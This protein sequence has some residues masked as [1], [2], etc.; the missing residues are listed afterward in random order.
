MCVNIYDDVASVFCVK[1]RKREMKMGCAVSL[2][3]RVAF[4]LKKENKSNEGKSENNVDMKEEDL[5]TMLIRKIEKLL[6]L[7]SPRGLLVDPWSCPLAGTGRASLGSLLGA[8]F[9]LGTDEVFAP[10]HKTLMAQIRAW[11]DGK[12]KRAVGARN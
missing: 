6:E 8:P 12:R 1:R 11:A 9:F 3:K 10:R 4:Y 7:V 5:R 2:R